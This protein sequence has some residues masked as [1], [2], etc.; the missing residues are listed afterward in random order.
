MSISGTLFC[1]F[2]E[3]TSHF[4][5]HISMVALVVVVLVVLWRNV[6]KQVSKIKT[7]FILTAH[8]GEYR[9]IINIKWHLIYQSNVASSLSF[10]YLMQVLIYDSFLRQFVLCFYVSFIDVRSYI[11]KITNLRHFTEKSFV[12]WPTRMK[13]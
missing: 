12:Y 5:I 1:L 2:S 11:S 7:K 9:I 6:A 13:S 4:T 10:Y 3:I 8:S